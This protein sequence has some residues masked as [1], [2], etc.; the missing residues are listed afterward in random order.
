MSSTCYQGFFLCLFD[1]AI[2]YQFYAGVILLLQIILIG[3]AG[4]LGALARYLLSHIVTAAAG[5]KF[6]YATLLINV[7]GSLVIGLIFVLTGRHLLSTA[8]QLILAT[9]FLGG[10]TTF[11]TMSWET[12]QLAR[13]GNM[14]ASITYLGGNVV[15]GL[16][17]ASL[18]LAIGW[19]V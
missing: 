8:M 11:S 6:P 5:T 12:V 2:C 9:G 14:R 4:A 16:L 18:G 13:G 15:L 19:G 10:Y 7:T 1:R 3:C 17:A